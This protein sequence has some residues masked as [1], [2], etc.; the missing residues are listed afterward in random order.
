MDVKTQWN[1]TLELL[2]QAYQLCKFTTEW[3]NNPIYSDYWPLLT[4]QDEWTIIK[5]V[6]EELRTSRY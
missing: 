1:T 6:M 5:Y 4:T 3:L 2:E